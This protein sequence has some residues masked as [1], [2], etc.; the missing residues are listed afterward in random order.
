MSK[1]YRL[2]LDNSLLIHRCQNVI[3]RV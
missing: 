3:E 1:K 2:I